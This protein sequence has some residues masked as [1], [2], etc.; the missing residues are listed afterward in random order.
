MNGAQDEAVIGTD[1]NC[2]YFYIRTLFLFPDSSV[3][4]ASDC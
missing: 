3:G 1:I 2:P 4:R